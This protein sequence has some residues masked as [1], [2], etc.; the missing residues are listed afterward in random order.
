MAFPYDLLCLIL[1]LL[2]SDKVALC[3]CCLVNWEFN[4]AGSRVLYSEIMLWP[5]FRSWQAQL[6]S[7]IFASASLPRNAPHVQVLRI[8]GYL[9]H[10]PPLKLILEVIPT[11]IKTFENLQT[12]EVFPDS[13]HPFTEI[14][15]E[16]EGR[17]SLVNLRVNSSCTDEASAPL[18]A[19]IE[20]LRQLELQRP[21]RAILQ[22]LPEWLGRLTSLEELHFTRDCGS[23][24]PGLLRSFIPLLTHITGFSLGLSYSLTDDD[25]FLFLA[26]LPC[27][28][29][30]QFRYYL[31]WK[32]P[33]PGPALK[34]LRSVTVHHEPFDEEEAIDQLCAVIQ[35][36]VSGAPV[37]RIR[38]VCSDTEFALDIDGPRGFDALIAHL[39]SA[40]ANLR[41]L[42][43]NVLPISA[44]SVALLFRTCH[45]LEELVI[46]T[47]TE[48]YQEF[49]RLLPT[50]KRLH[51]VALGVYSQDGFYASPEDAGRVMQTSDVLRRLSIN[52]VKIAGSWVSDSDG[53]RFVVQDLSGGASN[54]VSRGQSATQDQ[55]E[56]EPPA[57]NAILEEEEPEE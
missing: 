22:L 14:L 5:S 32:S 24:T 3:R 29:K 45:A 56:P 25:L 27:L 49:T 7:S 41:A 6:S 23:I 19:K 28:E 48:G 37:E 8:G 43:I 57:M 16:L 46:A 31:Q 2:A 34:R 36:A 47:D 10:P 35:R 13:D 18:L 42:D 40:N 1:D 17:P 21:T 53:V 38:L 50:M 52:D 39:C 55:K 15:T 30:L 12:V 54:E 11:A 4:R 20:G 44:P 33:Q 26:Q 9:P 51:T